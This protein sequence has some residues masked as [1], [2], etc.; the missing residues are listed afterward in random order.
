MRPE[1]VYMSL[2]YVDDS[3]PELSI[4]LCSVAGM[5]ASSTAL[6]PTS[7][8][9]SCVSPTPEWMRTTS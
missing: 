6:L 9:T 1:P 4:V 2:V 8:T 5:L 3:R 7:R